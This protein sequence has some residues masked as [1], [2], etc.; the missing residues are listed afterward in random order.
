MNVPFTYV[1]LCTLLEKQRNFL[2][3][4]PILENTDAT[5]LNALYYT[6]DD[7]EKYFSFASNEHVVIATQISV[8]RIF[9]NNFKW[10]Q[11]ALK[12]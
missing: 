10:I 5:E 4:K 12:K 11:K 9:D 7:L 8:L 1:D 6:C 3:T 2:L